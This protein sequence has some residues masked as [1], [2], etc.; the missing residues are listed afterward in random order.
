VNT[1]AFGVRWVSVRGALARAAWGGFI[2][3]G[4]QLAKGTKVSMVWLVRS[5]I[6]N[7][8]SFSSNIEGTEISNANLPSAAQECLSTFAQ[9]VLPPKETSV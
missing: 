9:R 3:A 8:K 5:H 4:K 7:C 6:W 2:R 1:E